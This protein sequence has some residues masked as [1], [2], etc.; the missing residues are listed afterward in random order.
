MPESPLAT[1]TGTSGSAP[2]PDAPGIAIISF[3]GK[4]ANVQITMPITNADGS[5]LTD[6]IRYY[7]L[8]HS[9][10]D[11]TDVVNHLVQ[12][13]GPFTAGQVVDFVENVEAY[14]TLYNFGALVG[15]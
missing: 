12:H 13:D 6:P 15:T 11:A 7:K 3:P 9:A 1:T 8:G 5:A 10:V 2:A 14:S 4:T